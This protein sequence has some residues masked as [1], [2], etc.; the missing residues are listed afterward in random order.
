MATILDRLYDENLQ[1]N[2]G[3]Y[4]KKSL[5]PE[6]NPEAGLLIWYFDDLNSRWIVET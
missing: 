4:E 1:K 2:Q 3:K 5:A 6:V